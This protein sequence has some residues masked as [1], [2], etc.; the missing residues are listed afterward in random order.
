MSNISVADSTYT[1]GGIDTRSTLDSTSLATFQNMNGAASG[2]VAVET[3]LGD[4]PT[5][6]GNKTDLVAR[7]AEVID[8]D[9][10]INAT[11][12]PASVTTSD[13][14]TNTIDDIFTGTSTTSGTPAPGIGT[15][16]LLKAE[17]ADESPSE[18]GRAAFVFAVVTAGAEDSVFR[19]QL[20]RAGAALA[21]A[22]QLD[23]TGTSEGVIRHANTA[24]RIYTFQ[25][26]S[27]TVVMRNTT[28]SL[29]NKTITTGANS[30][31]INSGGVVKT[32]GIATAAGNATGT[33]TDRYTLN[34][35][36]FTPS[37]TNNTA[38]QTVS[39]SNINDPANT[40]PEF[41]VLTTV[42]TT[43]V[44]WLY[45]TASDEPTI[46]ITLDDLTGAIVGVWSSDDPLPSGRP[47]I[48]TAGA[49]SRLLTVTELEAWSILSTK[50]SEADAYIREH[51][52]KPQYQAYRA[53][54]LLTNESQAKWI[55]EN[56][57][58]K[59]GKPD[60]KAKVKLS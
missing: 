9:G 10:V 24:Q 16:I 42:G 54:Q 43:T 39:A 25:D 48:H 57:E 46:W 4:G 60:V 50:A 29:T 6:K 37:I 23:C 34:A 52:L 45:I 21:N 33:G 20:R 41:T 12:G 14:R 30:L 1:T 44:R 32:G 35:Y 58:I 22:W 15:G 2:V 8:A 7:L 40:T 26:I 18:I 53:L 38:N 11:A 27:D 56:C 31:T 47:G 5:L 49:T 3:I 28:D 55:L 59:G 36:A 19:I 17:S 13:S 51:K